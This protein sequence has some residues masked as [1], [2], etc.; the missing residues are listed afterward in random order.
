MR[1]LELFVGRRLYIMARNDHGPILEL[2]PGLRGLGR[3]LGRR[4][5]GSRRRGR[6]IDLFPGDREGSVQFATTKVAG[7]ENRD[8]EERNGEWGASNDT[9]RQ[10]N[11]G[12]RDS[13][14]SKCADGRYCFDG[15]RFF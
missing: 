13:R 9:W 8:V 2:I 6:G 3:W 14:R 11:T 10:A 1:L 5:G 12:S 7:A 15:T 4:W